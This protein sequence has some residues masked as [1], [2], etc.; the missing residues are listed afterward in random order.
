MGRPPV[1]RITFACA[2]VLTLC[3]SEAS[4][5]VRTVTS[6]GAPMFWN[7]TVITINA[8]VG[9]PPELLVPQDVLFA[10]QSAANT[11]SRDRVGC[12]SIELRVTSTQER[13]ALVLLDG[14]SRMTFRRESWCREP[15]AAGEAC[16][17]PLALAVTSVFARKGDGEI[18]DA[19]VELNAVNFKW[20][21]L[22]RNPSDMGGVQDL[23]NTLTHEFGHLIGLDHTCFI[24]EARPGAVDDR[25]RPV[26]SCSQASDEI[27]ATTMFAAVP[28]GDLDRRSLSPDDERAVCEVYPPIDLTLE[29]VPRG[30]SLSPRRPSAAGWGALALLAVITFRRARRRAPG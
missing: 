26:P 29:G 18:I 25:G 27:K 1:G 2:T 13:S 8:Y 16:Y 24:G 22:V 4:A 28:P 30:C 21:D 3:S 17:D 6:A 12:T 10:A 20:A 5:Y 7:R 15:P 19:D 23:Q 9:D 11:W 14:T